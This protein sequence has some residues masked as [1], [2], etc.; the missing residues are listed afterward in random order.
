MKYAILGPQKAINRISDTEPQGLP[1]GATFVQITD[2]QAQQVTALRADH[3]LPAWF[4]GG[5]T[6]FNE[7]MNL[8]PPFRTSPQRQAAAA[9]F[10]AQSAEVQTAFISVFEAISAIHSDQEVL[11]AIS[12]VTVPPALAGIKAALI[13]TLTP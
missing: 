8:A 11:R 2:E 7:M 9:F 13:D 12:A 1:P 4:R 3:K 10:R 5:V 6:T